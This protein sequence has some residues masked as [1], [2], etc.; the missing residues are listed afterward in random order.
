MI[1]LINPPCWSGKQCPKSVIS[2]S[3]LSSSFFLFGLWR[4]TT[5]AKS[6]VAIKTSYFVHV[7][8]TNPS[9]LAGS[10]SLVILL[11]NCA[12]YDNDEAYCNKKIDFD[13][14]FE[15]TTFYANCTTS[16]VLINF[17]YLGCHCRINSCF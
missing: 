1:S 4:T 14:I 2:L 3:S 10:R 5:V 13:K 9:S 7:R 16:M 17:I 6:N 15:S 8:R 12:K 11:A